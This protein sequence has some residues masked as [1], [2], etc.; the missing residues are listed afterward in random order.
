MAATRSAETA[1]SAAAAESRLLVERPSL[2]LFSQLFPYLLLV[3]SLFFLLAIT[4]YP[5]LFSA[6]ISFFSFKFGKADAFIGLGNYAQIFRDEIFWSSILTTIVFTFFAVAAEFLIGLGLALI[7]SGR[8][9][10]QGLFRTA[11]VIPM[12]VT[13][14]VV[15]I[16]W[17]LIFESNSGLVSAVTKA[18]LGGDHLVT[19]STTTMPRKDGGDAKTFSRESTWTLSPDGRTLTINTV[20]HSPRG[21]KTMKTVYLRS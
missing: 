1:E 5:L 13:P 15:G 19:T 11:F 10:F 18:T 9:R 2:A 4:V 7:I 16:I 14:V 20:M 17:R 3:P 21:D 12:I 6:R 8:V